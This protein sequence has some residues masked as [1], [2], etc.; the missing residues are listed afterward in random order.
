MA[1]TAA[2]P[3]TIDG[4]AGAILD[5]L[6]AF[7]AIQDLTELFLQQDAYF[8]ES[9]YSVA[10]QSTARAVLEE[11]TSDNGCDSWDIEYAIRHARELVSLTQ[12]SQPEALMEAD[13]AG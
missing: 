6:V 5:G 13:D 3:D 8:A 12:M 4:H 9:R 1:T 7:K 2:I 11:I 10:I